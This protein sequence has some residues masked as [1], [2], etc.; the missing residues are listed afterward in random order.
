MV[1][2][3][4]RTMYIQ[5]K[6]RSMILQILDSK[7]ALIVFD[8]SG[9]FCIPEEFKKTSNLLKNKQEEILEDI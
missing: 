3:Y 8:Q 6:I 2:Q 5:K 4:G 1:I 7:K 9:V